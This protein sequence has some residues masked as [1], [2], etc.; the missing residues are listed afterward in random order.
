MERERRAPDPPRPARTH[1]AGTFRYQWDGLAGTSS[2]CTQPYLRTYGA[3]SP[4]P[5][6]PS[7][8]MSAPTMASTDTRSGFRLPWSSDRSHD[9]QPA[10]PSSEE[11]VASGDGSEDATEDE[12]VNW[13][14][15]DLNKR[16]GLTSQPRPA[17][18]SEGATDANDGA[19]AEAI[20]ETP[21]TAP[22]D[23]TMLD[24]DVTTA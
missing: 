22:E 12:N 11:P 20:T 7:S 5:C 21:T 13:P 3:R 18:T 2:D 23:A 1:P 8:R 24:Q 17:E 6:M 4:R 19:T 14:E 9:Q 10:D 15:S 16:L